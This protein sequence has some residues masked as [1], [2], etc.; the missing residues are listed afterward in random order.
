M[1]PTVNPWRRICRIP[2]HRAQSKPSVH[3]RV[4][5]RDRVSQTAASQ[6]TSEELC[7][8]PTPR[9]APRRRLP[10][11]SS[12]RRS[13]GPTASRFATGTCSG[14]GLT[15]RRGSVAWPERFE[16][17]RPPTLT[18]AR[19]AAAAEVLGVRSVIPAHVDGWAHFSEGV[20]GAGNPL[21][22][23]LAR[24]LDYCPAACPTE[25]PAVR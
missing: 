4:P 14:R 19:A 16:R 8:Q 10:D 11:S 20:D 5:R 3:N 23:L 9:S 7:R 6:N 13:A 24:C 21:G 12:G 1:A 17:G 15:G 18:A 25:R 22:V 2:T